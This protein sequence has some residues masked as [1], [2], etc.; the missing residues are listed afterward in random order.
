MTGVKKK[1]LP[2]LSDMHEDISAHVCVCVGGAASPD[3]QRTPGPV[4][5]QGDAGYCQGWELPGGWRVMERYERQ[6][7]E[8]WQAE[9]YS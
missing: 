9:N 6:T 7:K 4:D 5:V 2:P 1:I 8:P 3:V